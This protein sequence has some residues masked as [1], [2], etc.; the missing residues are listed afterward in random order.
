MTE[1]REQVE[2]VYH[3]LKDCFSLQFSAGAL[4]MCLAHGRVCQ[5]KTLN[6]EEDTECCVRKIT[7][8]GQ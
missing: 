5:R 2:N 6:A 8:S 1:D 7:I 3:H 4:Q